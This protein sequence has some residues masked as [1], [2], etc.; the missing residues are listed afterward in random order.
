MG[1]RSVWYVAMLAAAEEGGKYHTIV[2]CIRWVDN[3]LS[4]WHRRQQR[5]VMQYRS[6]RAA[7]LKYFIRAVRLHDTWCT[8]S[9]IETPG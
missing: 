1:K 9:F 3:L 5:G 2:L 8:A 4:S 6:R 7:D